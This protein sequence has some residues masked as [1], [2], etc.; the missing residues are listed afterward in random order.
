MVV[1]HV[2]TGMPY[3]MWELCLAQL[4]SSSASEDESGLGG[5]EETTRE[6][7]KKD[8]GLR[9]TKFPIEL[10]LIDPRWICVICMYDK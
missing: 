8:S 5:Q 6:D 2:A 10:D 9:L 1:N 7:E 4:E 3:N